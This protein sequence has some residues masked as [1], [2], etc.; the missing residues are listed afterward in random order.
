M[1]LYDKYLKHGSKSERKK[2]W[3]FDRKRIPAEIT[4]RKIK[5]QPFFRSE[6][7]KRK[8]PDF[9]PWPE[10]SSAHASQRKR[11][12]SLWQTLKFYGAIYERKDSRTTRPFSKV[13]E[14]S[15]SLHCTKLFAARI[16]FAILRWIDFLNK[17]SQF[18]RQPSNGGYFDYLYSLRNRAGLKELVRR[19]LAWLGLEF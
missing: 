11:S 8:V 2:I 10:A 18:R 12:D 6:V 7:G 16:M 4:N 14:R 9:E 17:L 19:L 15:L 5:N 1:A 13:C 3:N